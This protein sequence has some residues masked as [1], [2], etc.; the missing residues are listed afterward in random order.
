MVVNPVLGLQDTAMDT[1]FV[2]DKKKYY[3]DMEG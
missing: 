2:N 1:L 3:F